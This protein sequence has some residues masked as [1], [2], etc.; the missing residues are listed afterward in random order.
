[1]KTLLTVSIPKAATFIKKGQVVAFP[2]ETVYGLGANVYDEKAIK[3]I[4][5]AKG[6]PKDNPLIVHITSKKDIQVLVKEIPETAKKIISKFFPGPITI[7]LKKNEIISNSV[8]AGLDTIAIRMPSSK[9]ARDLIKI[10]GVPIAAPSANL[11][12]SPSPTSFMHV[13]NDFRG[14]IPC[15]LI[16]PN[17]KYGLESTVIDCTSAVPQILRPGVITLEQLRKIDKRIKYKSK[18]TKIKSPGQKYK[19]YAPKAQLQI[20]NHKL[21]IE[22]IKDNSAFIGLAKSIGN[23]F[24]MK[25]ICKDMN[26]YAKNLFSFFRECDNKGIKIIYAEKVSEKGIGL[27]IMNRLKKAAFTVKS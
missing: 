3:K 18:T 7:I 19:H 23:N 17:A 24:A 21:Q 16:G 15:I 26:V 2:T 9:I 25:K 1:M 5:K 22:N 20:T 10:C 11:S 6:R 12:G 27:A 14:K 8:T 13:L 4:F